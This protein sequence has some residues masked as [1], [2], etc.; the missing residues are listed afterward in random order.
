MHTVAASFICQVSVS[1]CS[2]HAMH[3]TGGRAV[4]FSHQSPHHSVGIAYLLTSLAVTSFHKHDLQRLNKVRALCAA[5][6]GDL[7]GA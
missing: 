6:E 4:G 5:C 3:L 2:L 7:L 1:P